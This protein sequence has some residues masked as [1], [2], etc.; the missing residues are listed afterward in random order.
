MVGG[1]GRKAADVMLHEMPVFMQHG[2][3]LPDMAVVDLESLVDRVVEGV[4]DVAGMHC[5][6]IGGKQL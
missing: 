1:D 5:R 4:A 2:Q 6:L 3:I